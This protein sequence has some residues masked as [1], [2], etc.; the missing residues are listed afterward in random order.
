MHQVLNRVDNLLSFR[1][2]SRETSTFFWKKCES[3]FIKIVV[4][5]TNLKDLRYCC[6]EVCWLVS[7]FKEIKCASDGSKMTFIFMDNNA[8]SQYLVCWYAKRT[9]YTWWLARTAQPWIFN[10]RSYPV[11]AAL[12]ICTWVKR[13][14]FL[15]K[16]TRMLI[17]IEISGGGG[18]TTATST[19]M[20]GWLK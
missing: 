1:L 4:A 5:F 6:W 18:M 19:M 10:H 2:W 14:L 9:D 13:G 3:F 15:Q 7:S 12:F 17:S 8:I 20:A 16:R 11:V